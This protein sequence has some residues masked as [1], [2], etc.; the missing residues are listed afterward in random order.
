MFFGLL[1]IISTTLVFLFKKEKDNSDDGEKKSFEENLTVKQTYK[2][3]LNILWLAPI[4][5]IILILM[6]VKVW[7]SFQFLMMIYFV[8]FIWMP[9]FCFDL[10]DKLCS[11]IHGL[12]KTN[13]RFVFLIFIFGKKLKNQLFWFDTSWCSKRKTG[14]LSRP[15]NSITNCFASHD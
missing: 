11:W 6:T 13:W 2:L 10:L 8:S 14:P 3:M 5:K 4:K 7:T 9:T 12:F 1:F 15:I